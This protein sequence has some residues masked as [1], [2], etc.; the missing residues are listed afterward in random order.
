VRRR[1]LGLAVLLVV[2]A[3]CTSSEALP[4]TTGTTATGATGVGGSPSPDDG[5]PDP[6][7]EVPTAGAAIA[8]AL[9][10]TFVANRA[11]IAAWTSA[12]DPSAWPP[13]EDVILLTLYEQRIDRVLASHPKLA[14]RVLARVPH[15]VA[16]ETAA[17]V[18][19][20]AALFEHSTPLDEVPDF[21]I[22]KPEPADALLGYFREA[23]ERFGVRWEL[24]AAVMLVETRMG[25]VASRSSA[26]AQG[27]MQFLPAT[28]EVYGLGGDIRDPHDAILGAANY[29]HESGAPDD[30]R[31]ALYTYNPVKAYVTAV[32]QY[33][34]TMQRFPD[35]Y[36]AYYDW[37][38]FVRTV[39][40]DVR[41]SG[42]GT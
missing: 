29:L 5:L 31:A 36:Y 6:E 10:D 38:V 11:A 23:E 17:N 22:R 24:L 20:G 41:L 14:A 13:P 7:Q 35:A 25:R 30:E 8:R 33:A 15:R 21:R 19:A 26:G 42:P 39:D 28:W 3:A 4:R 18:R 9:E 40:G 32:S 1:A 16:V 27:P 37:Q 12:G 2:G 34:K